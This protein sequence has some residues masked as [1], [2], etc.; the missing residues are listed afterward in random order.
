MGVVLFS[1]FATT[2]LVACGSDD[3]EDE[4]RGSIP[5]SMLTDKDGNAVLLSSIGDVISFTYDANGKLTSFSDPES[6]YKVKGGTFVSYNE[7]GIPQTVA[8]ETNANGLISKMQIKIDYKAPDG[9]YYK[10]DITTVYQYNSEQQITNAIISGRG[11][12]YY[13]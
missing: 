11:E 13:K 4:G 7:D 6:E 1:L 10:S 9:S 8:L 12:S 2:A 5:S 3:D